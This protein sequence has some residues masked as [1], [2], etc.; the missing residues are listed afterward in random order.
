MVELMLCFTTS[1]SL[2][3]FNFG[4]FKLTSKPITA[5]ISIKTNVSAIICIKYVNDI[6]NLNI[7]INSEIKKNGNS[8]IKQYNIFEFNIVL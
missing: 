6:P 8:I 4:Y 2:L 1:V 3:A 5:D 7:K